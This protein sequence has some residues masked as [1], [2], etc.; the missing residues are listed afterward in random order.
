MDKLKDEQSIDRVDFTKPNHLISRFSYSH[1]IIYRN[2]RRFRWQKY[3]GYPN[4]FETVFGEE[5]PIF[6]YLQVNNPELAERSTDY[7]LI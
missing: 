4:S 6:Y 2:E 3:T 1:S 5:D 7:R